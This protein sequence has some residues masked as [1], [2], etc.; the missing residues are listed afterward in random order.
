[1]T[2]TEC[3]FLFEKEFPPP[4]GVNWDGD[5]YT[6]T[7]SVQGSFSNATIWAHMWRGFRTAHRC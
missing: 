7:Q 2:V 6:G 1:M 5:H 4:D 3:R